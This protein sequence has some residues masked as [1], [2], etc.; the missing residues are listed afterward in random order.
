MAHALPEV[1]VRTV[2]DR[3]T[4]VQVLTILAGFVA[5]PLA[6]YALAPRLSPGSDLIRAIAPFSFASVLF[7]GILFWVGLGVITVLTGGL[8]R[9][10][11]G[12]GPAGQ[13]VDPE[14]RLVPPGYGSFIALGGLVGGA[15][16]AVGALLSSGSFA[17]AFV[18]WLGLGLAYG[19]VL[20]SAAHHGYLPFPD[21]D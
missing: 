16:G 8:L 13:T 11:K 10:A 12:K 21:D 18:G 19:T 5:G 7:F 6:A 17:T 2:P 3:S 9:K 14:H 1:L 4:T 15:V 20:W